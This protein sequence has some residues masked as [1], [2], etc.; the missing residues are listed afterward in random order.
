MKKIITA[1][2]FAI[3]ALTACTTSQTPAPTVTITEQAPDAPSFNTD[4]GVVSKE[5][6]YI[7]GVRAVGNYIIAAASDTELLEMGQTVCDVLSS[8]YTIDEV[9]EML[10]QAMIN[11]GTTSEEYV[12]AI[13][14]ILAGATLFLCP[15]Y[16]V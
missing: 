13:S 5:A 10:V 4:D 7:D 14:S 9:I 2:V 11:N 3:A 8:G 1:S 12:D 16:D 6:Q 15:Q